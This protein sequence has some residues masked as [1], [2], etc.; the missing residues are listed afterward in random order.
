MEMAAIQQDIDKANADLTAARARNTEDRTKLASLRGVPPSSATGVA[1]SP[2]G[3]PG[4][5]HATLGL[6]LKDD[7]QSPGVLVTDV[8]QGSPAELAGVRRG[9]RIVRV[10]TTPVARAEDAARAVA[11][12][13]PGDT[14]AIVFL[15][16]GKE[17]HA[18]TA[19]IS[20]EAAARLA[21]GAPAA[22]PAPAP[23]PAAPTFVGAT[24]QPASYALVV[25]IDHYR[26]VPG[27][28][29]ARA[30]AERFAQLAR[31][32]L[33]LR[34]EH[35]R[36]AVDDHATR[37][38]VLEGLKW[39]RDNVTA[40]GRV[41]FFFSGHGAPSPDSATY[42]VPYDGNA[43][44]IAGTALAMNDVMAQ[45][46]Q[47]RARE[48]L[49]V[50]DACFSGAGGRSVLP[51]G[52]R[53]LMRVKEAAPSAQMALFTASQGDEIS[54]PAPG[55]NAG[56]F[57]KYVT[58]GLGTGAADVNGDGQVSLQELSDW[59]SPRVAQAARRDNREQHPKLAVGSGVG[60]AGNFIV[61]YGLP[62]R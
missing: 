60:D 51:P 17:E 49:A 43:R 16:A 6:G 44:D 48:V 39:L 23:A 18:S 30:D 34:D 54:G 50:V 45:L 1:S 38:D 46:G 2:D 20:R 4:L 58:T 22:A 11:T 41:Y 62:T 13:A 27:A 26:D 29:G 28:P 8:L 36:L 33:G 32:T 42:L 24:P 52:A 25:G 5:P 56:A 7:G 61:A 14:L 37:T 53:P 10:G 19:V 15:R 57:T 40:G 35:V 47:T 59:V 12:L 3:V 21:A 55:E 9:D 31:Q